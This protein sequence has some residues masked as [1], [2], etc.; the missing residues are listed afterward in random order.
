MQ[1]SNAYWMY[2]LI[3]A[4]SSI[5]CTPPSTQLLNFQRWHTIRSNKIGPYVFLTLNFGEIS[6]NFNIGGFFAN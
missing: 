2:C 3:M 5:D 6:I 1:Q 4:V